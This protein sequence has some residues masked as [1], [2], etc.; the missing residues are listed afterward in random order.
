MSTHNDSPLIRLYHT[1]QDQ[2][3]HA[4]DEGREQL[5]TLRQ[6]IV[7]TKEKSAELGE[8]TREEIEAVGNYLERDL[9]AAGNYLAETG[10]DLGRWFQMEEALIEDRLKELFRKMA[11]PTRIALQQ[12]DADARAAQRYQQGEVVG[13]GTLECT[14]CGE[15]IHFQEIS[16]IPDCP[17][18]GN[19]TFRRAATHKEQRKNTR[20]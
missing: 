17:A 4:L 14:Q 7:E 19:S 9:E 6:L 20:H 16:V 13:M 18:C 10:D 2:L 12:L 3:H 1:L 5:P 15:P 8:L 11:D